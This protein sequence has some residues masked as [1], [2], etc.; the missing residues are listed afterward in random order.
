MVPDEK[1]VE[2]FIRPCLK[3]GSVFVD[4]GANVGYYTLMASKLVGPQGR[5]YSIEPIPSTVAILKS[6]V[7]INNCS[8]IKVCNAA[9]WSSK[10]TLT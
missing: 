9:A 8:N 4:V 10:G 7:K 2:T 5:V 6:N 1:D 3:R